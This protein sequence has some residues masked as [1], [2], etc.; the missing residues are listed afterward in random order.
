MYAAMH[1][2]KG[3]GCILMQDERVVAYALRQLQP[4]EEKYPTHNLELAAIVFTLKILRHF[5]YGAKFVVFT[6]HK[7]LKYLFDQKELNLR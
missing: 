6:D 2:E 5:L 4:Y 7:S 3:L 1:P